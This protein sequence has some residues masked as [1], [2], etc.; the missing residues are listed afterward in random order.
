[1][2]EPKFIQLD[3]RRLKASIRRTGASLQGLEKRFDEASRQ[4]AIEF[5]N[6]MQADASLRAPVL[7]GTLSGSG[8]VDGPHEEAQGFRVNVAFGGPARDYAAIQDVGG[9]IEASRAKALFIPL[10]RGVRP[11]DPG[12]VFGTDFVLAQSVTIPG[13]K[14]LTGLIPEYQRR[15][16]RVI[17][18]R[19]M[20][21]LGLPPFSPSSPAR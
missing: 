1:M 14:Y 15:A 17:G 9:I 13:N 11:G 3:E 6:E 5:A 18:K 19:T 12:L 20:E 4:A 21:L 8:V 16:T 2:A 7:E 10:R